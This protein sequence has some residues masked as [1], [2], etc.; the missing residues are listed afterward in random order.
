MKYYVILDRSTLTKYGITHKL[1]LG[2]LYLAQRREYNKNLIMIVQKDNDL[3]KFDLKLNQLY[4]HYFSG[5]AL[6]SNDIEF[7]E[8]ELS[9]CPNDSHLRELKRKYDAKKFQSFIRKY[10]KELKIGYVGELI[11]RCITEPSIVSERLNEKEFFDSL[12]VN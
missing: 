3:S 9:M 8:Y 1:W 7:I 4:I 10:K 5:F 11:H 12:K 6:T 2:R